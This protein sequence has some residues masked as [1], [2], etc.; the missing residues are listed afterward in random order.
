MSVS[1]NSSFVS[2]RYNFVVP[3]ESEFL[4]YNSATGGVI[5][6]AGPD[7]RPLIAEIC[8]SPHII[9]TAKLDSQLFQQLLAGE[10]LIEEGTDEV[11]R[12]RDRFHVAKV[13]TPI[14]LTLTT[15]MDCNL[16]CYYCYEERSSERLAVAD[17]P[18]VVELARSLLVAS[19]K[20]S[21]HVDWYGGEPLMNLTFLEE[22]SLALQKLCSDLTVMYSASV[23][24]NGT[25]WP[26]SIGEFL[27][28]HKIRQVQISFDGMRENHNKRRRYRKGYGEHGQL[29]SFDKAVDLVGK[30]VEHARVDLRF[31]IDRGN[32]QDVIPFVRFARS[33]GWFNATHRA[34]FQPA[35]LSS[36]SARSGFMRKTE[37]SI[38]EYERIRAVVREEAARTLTVEEA[39]VPDKFPYP[40]TSVCAALAT[41]SVVVGADAKLYRCGLQVGESGR[42]IGQMSTV[43]STLLPILNN[44]KVVQYSDAQWW[45]NFDPTVLSTC[46]QCS[47][48]PVCWGGCPK[49]HLEQDGHALL[50]QGSYWRRNLPRLVAEGVGRTCDPK[51]TFSEAEQFRQA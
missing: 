22:A 26:E 32:E 15:T 35:R 3:V 51:F 17:V 38:D 25:S 43:G 5:S 21:L 29:S 7:A 39:E 49:K 44:P 48:L 6:L 14:V 12:I 36:Y 10:F 40:R 42:A 19:R 13:R 8:G 2:S 28:R 34:V 23:I 46:S 11:A 50:E 47:F 37:L 9:Q 4:L 18:Q 1:A 33:K 27:R 30:L 16:G 24:S 20:D 41:D 31:N 45:R